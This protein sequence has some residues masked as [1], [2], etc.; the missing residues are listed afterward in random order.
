MSISGISS[1]SPPSANAAS[2]LQAALNA[3]GGLL[4]SN[5]MLDSLSKTVAPPAKPSARQILSTLWTLFNPNNNNTLTKSDVQ[6]AI[7]TLG[8]SAAAASA[9]WA[10]ISPFG[11][12]QVSKTSFDSNRFLAASINADLPAV[13]KAFASFSNSPVGQ[14]DKAM[15]LLLTSN[16]VV[17]AL[18]TQSSTYVPPTANQMFSTLWALFDVNGIKT[19]SQSDVQKAVIAEGGTVSDANALWKQLAPTGAGSIGA[20]QFISSK[21]VQGAIVANT[22]AVDATVS[23]VQLNSAGT[24]NSVLDMFS[25]GS[26]NILTGAATGFNNSPVGGPGGYTNLLNLFV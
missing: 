18:S 2:Q 5:G 4:T 26:A 8:G 24:S 23:R 21:F 13:Q 1:Y 15:T 7:T 10:E 19:V 17:S 20:T 14:A 16:D 3:M 11:I 25:S 9:I 6:Q 22:A 12:N